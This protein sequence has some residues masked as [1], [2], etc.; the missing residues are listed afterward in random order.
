MVKTETKKEKYR[1][2]FR[3]RKQREYREMTVEQRKEHN[4]KRYQKQK[5]Q[6]SLLSKTQQDK[7]FQHKSQLSKQRKWADE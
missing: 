7:W 6:L 3:L 1:E 5:K 2:Y 4:A